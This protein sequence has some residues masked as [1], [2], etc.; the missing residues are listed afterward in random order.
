MGRQQGREV[1]DVK[2]D[3]WVAGMQHMCD[4]A[5]GLEF[6]VTAAGCNIVGMMVSP[7]FSMRYVIWI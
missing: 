2:A 1:A 5:E 7:H 3:D 4:A 6:L